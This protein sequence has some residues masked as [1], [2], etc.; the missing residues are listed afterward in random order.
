MDEAAIV[1][2]D[3]RGRLPTP[4]Q[5]HVCAT[6]SFVVFFSFCSSIS[7]EDKRILVVV[8]AILLRFS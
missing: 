8:A 7:L 6:L 2:N 1:G 5:L 3:V 4:S